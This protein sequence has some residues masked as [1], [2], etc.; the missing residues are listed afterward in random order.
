MMVKYLPTSTG[1]VVY[2]YNQL[3]HA[4][5]SLWDKSNECEYFIHRDALVIVS[6]Q[7]LMQFYMS[8]NPMILK[9]YYAVLCLRY[10]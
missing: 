6:L 10:C 8:G 7:I 3:L 4:G 5:F 9:Q 2:I 1:S